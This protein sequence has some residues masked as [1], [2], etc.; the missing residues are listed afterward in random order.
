MGKNK[1]WCNLPDD[2]V[3]KMTATHAK[4]VSYAAKACSFAVKMKEM[5]AQQQKQAAQGQQEQAIRLPTG[6]L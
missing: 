1:E 6:P 2:V 4:T 5:Q 3:E